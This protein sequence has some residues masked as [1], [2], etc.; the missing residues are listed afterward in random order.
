MTILKGKTIDRGQ[1]QDHL[2]GETIKDFKGTTITM[3]HEVKENT[4]EMNEM[5]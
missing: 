4:F 1:S 5:K 2:N 3:L